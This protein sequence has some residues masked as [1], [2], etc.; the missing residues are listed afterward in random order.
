MKLWA[1]IA[2]V[3]EEVEVVCGERCGEMEGRSGG[4]F[5]S[6]RPFGGLSLVEREDEEEEAPAESIIFVLCVFRVPGG[7]GYVY[8]ASM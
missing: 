2:E 3:E 4:C 8:E 1:V 5:V 7:G 6:R